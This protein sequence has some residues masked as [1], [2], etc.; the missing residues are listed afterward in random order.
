MQDGYCCYKS[1][2]IFYLFQ[3]QQLDLAFCFGEQLS[4]QIDLPSHSYR[5]LKWFRDY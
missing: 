2:T 1:N 5:Y 4:V 3:L